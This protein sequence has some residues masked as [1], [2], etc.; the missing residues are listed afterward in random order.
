MNNIKYL[1]SI[2]GGAV[3]TYF[4]LYGPAYII[5]GA[6][7]LFDIVTGILAS[8]MDGAGLSSQKAYKGVIKKIV[9]FVALAFGT[10]LDVFMPYAAASVNMS[11][12][13]NL[14]FSSVICV[15]IAVTESISIIEN[16]YRCNNQA[17]PAW[18]A[19]FLKAA[20]DD[21]DSGENAKEEKKND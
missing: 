13:K 9:L 1:L 14:L 21:L 7:V 16:I 8:I 5:V 12:P 2:A 17:L 11:I 4:K 19:K 20:K 15:Y 18:I 10:F 3:L 6:A